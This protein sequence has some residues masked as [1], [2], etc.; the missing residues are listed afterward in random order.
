MLGCSLK[1]GR[2]ISVCFQGKSFNIMVIQVHTS[3]SNA[4]E[5]EVG[6]FYEDLQDF[7]EKAM[8]PHSSILAWK[9]PWTEEPG[10]LQSMGSRRVGHD[11]ATSLS[12]FTFMHWRRKWQATPVFLPG[13][14]QGRGSLVGCRLWGRTESD[15]T[16]ATWQ[17]HTELN[18]TQILP[19]F[20]WILQEPWPFQR[21][22]GRSDRR[23]V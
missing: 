9:N 16:E 3:T 15:T 11:W 13:E 7:L 14:S 10:R 4:E 1:N 17:Q 22:G 2:M 20:R 5:A 21:Q 6:R 12:L 19:P 8:A 23:N 18:I